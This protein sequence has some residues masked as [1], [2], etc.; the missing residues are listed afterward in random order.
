MA[1]RPTVIQPPWRS[2]IREALEADRPEV[3][4][5]WE[6]AGEAEDKLDEAFHKAR[7]A[8]Q[9]TLEELTEMSPWLPEAFLLQSAQEVVQ[10]DLLFFLDE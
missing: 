4:A 6:E 7:K 9:R 8:Y 1:S 5:E 10:Q 2:M 3:L